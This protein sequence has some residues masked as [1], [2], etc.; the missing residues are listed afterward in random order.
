MKAK[1]TR[2]CVVSARYSTIGARLNDLDLVWDEFD[3]RLKNEL[4]DISYDIYISSGGPGDPLVSRF[5]DWDNHSAAG[6]M[7]WNA[8]IIIL[9]T[10]KKNM[11]SLSAILFS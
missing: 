11:S 5:E 2:A 4:P 7:K 1:P 8:G 10:S 3:V 6:W 9:P